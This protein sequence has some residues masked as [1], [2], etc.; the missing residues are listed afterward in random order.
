MKVYL[1][2]LDRR[3]DRLA[4]MTERLNA[5]GL[6]FERISAFDGKNNSVLGLVS[7]MKA[8]IY[9]RCELPPRGQ[10]GVYYS[11]RYAWQR[12]L[13]ANISQAL[14]LEDDAIP[15]NWDPKIFEVDLQKLGIDQLRIEELAVQVDEPHTKTQ[16]ST[17]ILGCETFDELSYGCAAYIVTRLGAEKML[18]V[19]KF[20]FNIDHFDMW[21]NVVGLRTVLL[22][23]AM[24]KQS[25]SVSDITPPKL[26]PVQQG[27]AW[28]F[29]KE[30]LWQFR[31]P[32]AKLIKKHSRLL[33]KKY[34]KTSTQ[35]G[36]SKELL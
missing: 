11:H 8:Y 6:E 30:K 26:L 24:W 21:S 2:N 25:E 35:D 19:G 22:R 34:T 5:L 4:E 32:I 15:V 10:I 13:D 9:N 7:W 1:I 29:T 28:G 33:L 23:P 3:P 31:R 20:W 16:N 14:I 36:S 18:R 17:N 12:I 27:I